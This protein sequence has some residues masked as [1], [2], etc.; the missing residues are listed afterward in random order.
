V[1]GG[2]RRSARPEIAFRVDVGRRLVEVLAI[3]YVGADW[4]ARAR[5]RG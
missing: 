5:A 2:R 3:T 4:Q 1:P